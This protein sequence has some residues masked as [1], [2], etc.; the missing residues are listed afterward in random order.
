MVSLEDKILG[1]RGDN[2]CSSESDDELEEDGIAEKDEHIPNGL[3]SPALTPRSA[4]KNGSSANTGPKGVIEDWRLFC[5]MKNAEAAEAEKRLNE[6]AKS[7]SMFC[8]TEENENSADEVTALFSN[9]DELRQFALKR[10]EELR[11]KYSQGED[12]RYGTIRELSSK[13][14]MSDVIEEGSKKTTVFIHIYEK[15]NDVPGCAAM[16]EAFRDMAAWYPHFNFCRS[17]ASAIGMSPQFRRYGLP[18]LQVYKNKELILN[19]VRLA[20]H[21]GEDFVAEDLEKLLREYAVIT[22]S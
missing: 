7:R 16:D 3:S 14:E 4:A 19:L 21:L 2:Y 6:I 9:D 17:R 22:E 15:A 18:T 12:S 13:E 10:M 5:R 11:I 20:D 1:Y 8:A